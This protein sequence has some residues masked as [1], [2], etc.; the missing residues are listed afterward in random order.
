MG[1]CVDPPPDVAAM[2]AAG[3]ADEDGSGVGGAGAGHRASI[4]FAKAPEVPVA[5][6]RAVK[7]IATCSE[8]AAVVFIAVIVSLKVSIDCPRA[9]IRDITPD[10]MNI[11]DM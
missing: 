4:R 10:E 9:E 7:P 3:T 1:G 6:V 5:F 2:L 11:V 8:V